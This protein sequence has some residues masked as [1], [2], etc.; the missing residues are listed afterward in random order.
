MSFNDFYDESLDADD[1][2]SPDEFE[3]SQDDILDDFD[4]DIYGD[5]T[6]NDDFDDSFESDEILK[7]KNDFN[8][9]DI[10]V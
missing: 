6:D 1:Y 4:D 5:M 7:V 3:K 2:N 10:G 9:C 8:F